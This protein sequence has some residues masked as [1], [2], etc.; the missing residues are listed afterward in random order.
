MPTIANSPRVSIGLAV[1]NGLGTVER[2][3][4]SILAQDLKDL[5]LVVC[6]NVSDDKTWESLERYAKADARIRISQNEVNIGSHENMARVLRLS[7]GELF[8]WISADDWL[9]PQCL[10]KCVAAL[11]SQP[12]AIGVTTG[13][14]I[15]NLRGATRYEDYAGAFPSGSDPAERFSRMLW[16]FHAGDA[17]Y[18]PVYG[19]YRRETLLQ[20]RPLRPSERTDWLLSTELALRGPILHIPER[21]AHRTSEHKRGVDRVAFR[22][23]LDPVRGERIRTSATRL[24][25]QMQALAVSA[26]LADEEMR[27]CN[28]ALR[29]FWTKEAIRTFRL[30]LADARS[31]LTRR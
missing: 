27:R 10:S 5:E 1:R 20:C 17:K 16:F 22:R 29:R 12:Q 11:D 4:E 13:F 19:M 15:H 21:L 26:D 31:R 28:Q 6:D 30:R 9:E 25:R 14:T 7:R 23:R 3:I 2:C 18:D 24:Y 8:R